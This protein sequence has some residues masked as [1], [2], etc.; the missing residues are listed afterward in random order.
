ML[1]FV[2]EKTRSCLFIFIPY[3]LIF[4]PPHQEKTA[5]KDR[6]NTKKIINPF[7]SIFHPCQ[8]NFNSH[9]PI[10][11][12]PPSALSLCVICRVSCKQYWQ[13]DEQAGNKFPRGKTEGEE[14][15]KAIF[16]IYI[17]HICIYLSILEIAIL[18]LKN[19]QF[20]LSVRCLLVVLRIG[21]TM[22]TNKFL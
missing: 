21:Q 18:L 6:F 5:P 20:Q 22:F 7:I 8:E 2:N 15:R 4:L 11:Q 1:A 3:T 10:F 14:K 17:I 9:T 16:R 19:Q 12:P 13:S